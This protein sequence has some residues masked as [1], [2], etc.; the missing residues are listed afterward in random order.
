MSRKKRRGVSLSDE[1]LAMP[2][3]NAPTPDM[4]PDKG[5]EAPY[6]A[7]PAYPAG[8]PFQFSDRYEDYALPSE[9]A[10]EGNGGLMETPKKRTIFKPRTRKPSFSKDSVQIPAMSF[11]AWSPA[12]S[13]SGVRRTPE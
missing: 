5:G 12:T 13:R 8:E 9:W 2:Q 7:D 1:G 6:A 11:L 3:E 10:A 4:Y